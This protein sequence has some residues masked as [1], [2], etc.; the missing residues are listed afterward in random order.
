MP[1]HA[2]STRDRSREGRLALRVLVIDDSRELSENMSQLLRGAGFVVRTAASGAAGLEAILEWKPDAVLMDIRLPDM[3]GHD[4][5]ARVRE[6][7]GPD[8]WIAA[9]TG[10]E[11]RAGAEARLFDEHFLKPIDCPGLIGALAGLRP[12]SETVAVPD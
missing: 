11:P 6:R 4:L 12:R 2:A 8:V 9:V 3:D 5:A 10:C 1:E 7:V